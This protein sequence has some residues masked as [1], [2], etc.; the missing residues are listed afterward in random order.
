MAHVL[1]APSSRAA[2]PLPSGAEGA[3][4]SIRSKFGQPL[5]SDTLWWQPSDQAGPPADAIDAA[6]W[7]VTDDSA[8]DSVNV[9]RAKHAGQLVIG[10]SDGFQCRIA[11]FG[12]W[13]SYAQ[14]ETLVNPN[15][16]G[17]V[18]WTH[19]DRATNVA[20]LTGAVQVRNLLL[21]LQWLPF[22]KGKSYE[23]Q[24]G[25]QFLRGETRA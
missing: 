25:C 3:P 8:G 5:T 13:Y 11:S 2:P 22:F 21:A 7:P 16:A 18:V 6:V 20:T 1:L 4:A 24:G 17:H 12:S 15:S 19:W 23:I 14:F 10:N 9:C